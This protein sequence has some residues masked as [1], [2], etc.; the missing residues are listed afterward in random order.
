ME[1]DLKYFLDRQV[2]K[3]NHIDFIEADPISIPHAFTKR[4]D[5]EI[6]GF[7]AALFAWGSRKVILKKSAEL[8]QRMDL[9]PHDFV[10]YH[11]AKDLKQLQDFKHRTFT[12]SDLIYLISFL[13]KHYSQHQSLETA[14]SQWLPPRAVHIENALN[15]FY[16]YVFPPGK[17]GSKNRATKHIAAP[18]KNSTCKRL[19][20][21]LR[22]MVRKDKTGVDFGLWKKIKPAQ[23]ICP[24]DVHV[25]RVA[26]H[27]KLLDQKVPDWKAAVALT[28]TLKQLDA[29]DPVKYDFA[30]FGLGVSEKKL[31]HVNW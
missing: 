14:F 16:T 27:F 24:L 20:M 11:S 17:N 29:R 7:F 12:G 31:A 21:Y 5:I 22:W 6:A 26:R 19:N 3:F 30:L 15:G 18:F 4:Q 23:L 13:R 25:I 8:M 10:R 2:E 9:A 28:N 1:R